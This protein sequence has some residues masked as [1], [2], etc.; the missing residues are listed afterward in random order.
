MQW[1]ATGT[2]WRG[3]FERIVGQVH[4]H[5]SRLERQALD[6]MVNM[7]HRH[8]EAQGRRSS[9]FA[10][11]LVMHDAGHQVSCQCHRC[12]EVRT[13]LLAAG[14]WFLVDRAPPR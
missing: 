4:H 11:W 13:E 10:A 14:G 1:L 9:A 5:H 12:I 3:A 7:M 6:D 8:G 2:E